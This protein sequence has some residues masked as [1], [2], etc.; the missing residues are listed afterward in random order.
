[1][2]YLILTTRVDFGTYNVDCVYSWG[3]Q[4]W[5]DS[6]VTFQRVKGIAGKRK[7]LTVDGNTANN[8][9]EATLKGN[10]GSGSLGNTGIH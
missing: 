6:D 7:T 2:K 3:Y 9:Q 10:S 8:V 4:I 5:K 1:M